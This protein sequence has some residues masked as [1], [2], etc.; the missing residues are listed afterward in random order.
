MWRY[1]GSL[2]RIE[3]VGRPNLPANLAEKV[4]VSRSVKA[5]ARIRPEVMVTGSGKI[6]VETTSDACLTIRGPHDPGDVTM[7]SAMTIIRLLRRRDVIQRDRGVRRGGWGCAAGI[8]AMRSAFRILP[9]NLV[10]QVV[11][12][13]SL[14]PISTSE[15]GAGG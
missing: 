5:D 3:F 10:P 14:P 1:A 6:G 11:P 13:I 4:P 9:V 2:S 8:E 7:Q 12:P 15:G